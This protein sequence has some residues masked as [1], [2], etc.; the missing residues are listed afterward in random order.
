MQLIS[1]QCLRDPAETWQPAM[2]WTGVRWKRPPAAAH[3]VLPPVMRKSLAVQASYRE[4]EAS[5]CGQMPSAAPQSAVL[6]LRTQSPRSNTLVSENTDAGAKKPKDA[7]VTGS[8]MGGPGESPLM[9]HA[10]GCWG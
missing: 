4:P 1:W 7:G 8:Q 5:L 10:V 3:R 9:R 6:T 2:L